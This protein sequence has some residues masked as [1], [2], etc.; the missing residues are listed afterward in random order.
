MKEEKIAPVASAFPLPPRPEAARY[1]EAEEVEEALPAGPD[2]VRYDDEPRPRRRRAERWREAD[3]ARPPHPGF[4]WAVL[5]CILML[6]VAQVLPALGVGI[7]FGIVQVAR[8]GFDAGL[9]WIASPEGTQAMLLPTL[10]CAQVALILF[11][12]LVLRL[13]V[14]KDWPRQVALRLPGV[15]HVVL[16]VVGLPALAL[17]AQAGYAAAKALLPGFDALPCYFL[18]LGVVAAVVSGYWAAV[19]L[20]TGKDWTKELAR[21]D[22]QTQLVLATLG[23]LLVLV[24]GRIAFGALSP[25]VPSLHL[26]GGTGELMEDMVKKFQGWP[27]AL[28]VLVIGLGP[29]LG[30]ELWCRAFLGRGLVGRHGVVMGVLLTSFFFGLIHGDPHQGTMAALMGLVLHFAYLTTRSLWVPMLLHFLNNSL[31]VLAD[32]ILPGELQ[33]ID[34][35][36]EGI[37]WPVTAAAALLA[38]AVGWALYAGRARL[39]RVDGSEQP[40][41]QPPYPGVAYPPP[42]SGTAVVRP[43][44]P[45]LLP[46]LAVLL[47]VALLACAIAFA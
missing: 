4:W 2:R 9:Q 33:N 27:P 24:V 6:I 34:T 40:P 36:P 26:P 22:L 16:A 12:W 1:E 17:L 8:L 30:E 11:S 44:G 25:H 3:W 41:W 42:G 7:I 37:P 19:R 28:A 46:T 39:V 35:R 43:W 23:I 47:G 15:T 31:S 38:A 18:T 21:C 20:T 14:G 29:G 13:V 45:G 32:K 10:L 5:W